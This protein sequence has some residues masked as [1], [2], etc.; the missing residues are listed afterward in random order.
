MPDTLRCPSTTMTSPRSRRRSRTTALLAGL[1]LA[2]CCLPRV[3]SA[4]TQVGGYAL[5][6]FEPA[7]AGDAFFGVPS[8]W[9]P[10]H[11]TPRVHAM[12]DYAHEPLRLAE[13]AS[14]V[15]AQGFARIDASLT[16]FDRLLVSVDL[17][18]VLLQDGDSPVV[19][20]VTLE[21]PTSAEIGD[22]RI[23]ARARLLGEPRDPFQIAL[24]TYF[25]APTAGS[26]SYAGDG[27]VRV[28]PHLVLGGSVGSG[29]SFLWTATGGVMLRASDNP[30]AITYGAGAAV[31]FADGLLQLGPEVYATTQLGDTSPL[32]SAQVPI[33]ASGTGVE[34]LGGA[35]LRVLDGLTLGAAGGPGM[36]KAIGTPA[37]RAV[38]MLGWAPGPP[39]GRSEVVADKDDDGIADAVD[40]CR[41]VPGEPSDEATKNG[42]PPADRDGDKISDALDACPDQKGRSNAD[43]TRNG[44]PADY[45]RDSIADAEDA[46]P[47]QKGVASVDA[48]RHGCPGLVDTDADGV[49]DKS[50][51]CP[52]VKGIASSDLARNG[53]PDEATLD[54]DGDGIA[55]AADA[56]PKERG[57]ADGD[58]TRN[59]C[60]K[61]VAAAAAEPVI[62]RQVHFKFGK[63][64]IDET[65]DPVTLELL[66]EV[67]DVLKK[68]P[69]IQAIEVQGHADSQGEDT[70]NQSLSQARAASVRGWL[71]NRG[72]APHRLIAKGYG[73][74][75]P[76]GNN[77]D[78]AGRS[79]NRRVQF[80]IIKKAGAKP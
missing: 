43:A 50:D 65:V 38:V 6:Q 54:P 42:C 80:A 48:A 29:V 55:N 74:S 69:E 20:G 58:P 46:C 19:N 61:A 15:S 59:G 40:A 57:V 79:K 4:Q 66:T 63:A 72:I 27:A 7:V 71:I 53:C 13:G 10:G 5:N 18:F 21:S 67:R 16:L 68:H 47:N 78:E 14:V 75:Q 73:A 64:R 25:F 39:A 36:S 30:H 41:D 35:K 44:C 51:A 22:L 8:P 49:A 45:D 37:Y 52:K 3:A 1:A 17:P 23:G 70:F 24:G 60:P 76:A 2:A 62:L 33:E 56:C 9:T 11:L 28:N 26:E 31:V 32:S 77:D 34:I 12:F